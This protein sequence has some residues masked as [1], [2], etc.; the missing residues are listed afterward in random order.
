MASSFLGSLCKAGRLAHLEA[1]K[2]FAG[3]KAGGHTLVC[4]GMGT[5]H[6]RGGVRYA[7][8]MALAAGRGTSKPFYDNLASSRGRLTPMKAARSAPTLLRSHDQHVSIRHQHGSAVVQALDS[9]RCHSLEARPGGGV[10][11]VQ[12]RLQETVWEG[13]A[14]SAQCSQT[15]GGTVNQ[16]VLQLGRTHTWYTGSRAWLPP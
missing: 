9:A 1:V 13:S 7:Q 8:A 12:P 2:V 10:W 15:G 16:L 3:N 6:A 5:Q 14:F 4:G 11:V